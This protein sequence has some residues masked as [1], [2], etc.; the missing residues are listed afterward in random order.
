MI[1]CG[2]FEMARCLQPYA[3]GNRTLLPFFIERTQTRGKHPAAIKSNEI[4]PI[5]LSVVLALG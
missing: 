5:W 2:M 3:L 4:P 1:S